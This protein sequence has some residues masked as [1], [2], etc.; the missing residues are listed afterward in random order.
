[1]YPNSEAVSDTSRS[2]RASLL[3][4][5]G[6]PRTRLRRFPPLAIPALPLPSR[7][8]NTGGR[9]KKNPSRRAAPGLGASHYDRF[10]LNSPLRRPT[11][12]PGA[13]TPASHKLRRPHF[14]CGSRARIP[15]ASPRR[16]KCPGNQTWS[17]QRSELVKCATFGPEQ[18]QQVRFAEG[19]IA[20][21]SARRCGRIHNDQCV[22]LKGAAT[23]DA[24]LLTTSSRVRAK[25]VAL[26]PSRARPS[27]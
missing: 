13:D 22:S 12:W 24:P 25:P 3:S 2:G 8:A 23:L 5:R 10:G 16:C 11:R 4:L 7:G 17:P 19:L 21:R 18:A 14:G 27:M 15:D 1:V 20:I 9:Q 26:P 6:L